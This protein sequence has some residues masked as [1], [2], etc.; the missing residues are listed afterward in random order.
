MNSLRR[1]VGSTIEFKSAII[2]QSMN[3]MCVIV[4]L[5]KKGEKVKQR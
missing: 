3:L 2:N 1:R 5:M 4:R